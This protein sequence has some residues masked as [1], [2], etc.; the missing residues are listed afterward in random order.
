MIDNS[1]TDD[2]W[3]ALV[4]KVE[5]TSLVIGDRFPSMTDENGK[6]TYT[7]D[8]W[9]WVTGFWP[10]LLWLIY[11]DTKH[12]PFAKIALSC[13]NQ[14]DQA[15]NEY[16]NLHHDVG[17][18]W[19][20]TS[21]K[22]YTM[23][24]DPEARRRAL[25]AA[26]HLASRFNIAGNFLSAWNKNGLN[27]SDPRGLSIIDS[28]MNLPLLHWASEETGDPRFRHVAVAHTETVIENFI[29]DDFSVNHMVEFDPFTGEKIKVQSGQGQST[30]SAWSR[31]T[32]WAVHGMAL[33]YKYTQEPR[34]LEVGKKVSD[35]FISELPEDNVPHWDFR[36]PRDDDTPRDTSAGA[37]AASGMILLSSFLEGEESDKYLGAATA[38]IKSTYENYGNWDNDSDG[39]IHGG[40]FNRPADIGI[41]VSLI[42][43][44]YYYVE[45]LSKLRAL[46]ASNQLRVAGTLS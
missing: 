40:T 7:E 36:V 11:E 34:Y 27:D 16:V 29:R 44:D 18:M 22:R 46:N 28:M 6:Y 21:I 26:S 43:G 38:I 24:G 1:W 17:F 9:R 30:T 33:A 20:L 45:A 2:A 4:K 10:G 23:T 39:I 19:Q 12:E 8:L 13:E 37:C 14:M 3:K 31:G 35:F 5:K 15:L 25:I 42:Y 41:D 32:S